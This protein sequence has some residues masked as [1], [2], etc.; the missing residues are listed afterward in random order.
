MTISVKKNML[1]LIMINILVD[2]E[3]LVQCNTICCSNDWFENLSRII[4]S[5]PFFFSKSHP[6]FPESHLEA[7]N[8]FCASI[9]YFRVRILFFPFFPT[10][11]IRF[12]FRQPALEICPQD[13]HQSFA[14][15][16][17][18]VPVSLSY[19]TNVLSYVHPF[20]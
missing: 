2:L 5:L 7:G 19:S 13:T 6:G 15:G 10:D 11:I 16:Y 9:Q 14:V 1:I 20:K 17:H 3:R 18:N 12:Y 4:V 8:L